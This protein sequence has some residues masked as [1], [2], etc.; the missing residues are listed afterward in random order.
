MEPGLFSAKD[1]V[2]IGD[3]SYFVVTLRDSP[4]RFAVRPH[5]GSF[6]NSWHCCS[7]F[8]NGFPLSG[9]TYTSDWTTDLGLRFKQ[10]L[11]QVVTPYLDD[12]A[13]PDLWELLTGTS[14]RTR[15]AVGTPDELENFSDEEKLQIRLAIKDFRLVIINDFGPTKEQIK[16]IDER[17]KYLSEALEKHN[18]FDW[19]GIAINTAIAIG[20]A[21]SLNTEQGARLLQLFR[22]IFSNVLYLLR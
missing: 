22:Q 6:E 9:E 15:M 8:R 16:S 3:Y 4:L 2:M 19:K 17:L 1:D 12:I 21:L 7:Q 13:T 14:S 18:R 11:T 5:G 20:I 10:W